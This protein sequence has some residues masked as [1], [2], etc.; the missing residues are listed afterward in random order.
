MWVA[1]AAE[2][3]KTYTASQ[4]K[5]GSSGLGALPST[6][7]DTSMFDTSGWNVA[8]GGS[9]ISGSTASSGAKTQSPTQTPTIQP[10]PQYIDGGQ[11]AV[12]GGVDMTTVLVIG[13]A[14]LLVVVLIAKKR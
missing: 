8:T 12:G 14:A 2:I 10:L 6:G 11:S 3:Y 5:P 7:Q 1:A 9:R 13:G 4:A